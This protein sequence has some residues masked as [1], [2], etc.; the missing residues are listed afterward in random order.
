M[1]IEFLI[2]ERIAE[3][4]DLLDLPGEA[5]QALQDVAGEV[6]RDPLL[7]EIFT[8]FHTQT[9]L[10]GKWHTEWSDLPMDPRLPQRFGERASLFYLLAYLAAL[11][12]TAGRY[13]ELGISREVLKDTL[14]DV[15]FFVCD[16]HDLHG[17]WGFS[18]FSWIWLHLD[19]QLFRLGRLQYRQMPFPGGIT[20]FRKRTDGR[21]LLLAD[22]EMPLRGDGYASGAFQAREADQAG[23]AGSR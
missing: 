14:R 17:R 20:A 21:I 6:R 5:V 22:P 13:Q 11:P 8:Q 16:Y 4:N 15:Q 10:E 23:G 18:L 12:S 9:A 3:W 7:L 1:E 19:C 2:P